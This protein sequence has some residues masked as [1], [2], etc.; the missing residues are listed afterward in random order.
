LT[1]AVVADF[2]LYLDRHDRSLPSGYKLPLG[3]VCGNESRNQHSER[4]RA[5][6]EPKTELLHRLVPNTQWSRDGIGD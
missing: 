2:E 1:I 5:Q 4:Q 6:P 3:C